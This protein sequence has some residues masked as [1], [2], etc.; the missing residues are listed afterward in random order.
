[1]PAMTARR[2]G[3]SYGGRD[4]RRSDYSGDRRARDAR[5]D[6]AR[7]CDDADGR[8]RSCYRRD[9]RG[10]A[11]GDNVRSRRRRRQRADSRGRSPPQDYRSPP[12]RSLPR[13]VWADA[14]A[15]SRSGVVQHAERDDESPYQ[16]DAQVIRR[17]LDKFHPGP[18][19]VHARVIR[20]LLDKFHARSMPG[21]CPVQEI[22]EVSDSQPEDSAGGEEQTQVEILDDVKEEVGDSQQEDS[23]GEEGQTQVAAENYQE[24]ILD[25]VKEEV[26]DSQTEDSAG[27]EEQSQVEQCVQV[28]CDMVATDLV[29]DEEDSRET[30]EEEE[31]EDCAEVEND[32]DEAQQEGTI[33]SYS[34]VRKW[35]F[36]WPA[37]G[38][39]RDV[40][41]RAEDWMSARDI[42]QNQRVRYT[43]GRD[44]QNRRC[45][46]Y[47][48]ALTRQEIG[49]RG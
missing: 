42:Y 32:I 44:H 8:G 24:E 31:E 13:G 26:G 20:R 22:E 37:S 9:D 40:F 45:A 39:G 28:E 38:A 12:R 18:S 3:R 1:M 43:L 27:E 19:Q 25:D 35:G 16:V 49:V 30:E 33:V 7:R 10:R 41:F 21:P 6:R 48:K 46:R 4:R 5:D 23:A 17:L 34:S 14:R 47:V 29:K 11:G 36:I 2:D 15:R